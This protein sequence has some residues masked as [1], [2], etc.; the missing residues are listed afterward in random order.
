M[1]VM[2]KRGFLLGEFSLKIIIAVICIVI[3]IFLLVS[4]YSTYSNKQFLEQAKKSIKKI[5]LGL[6]EAEQK[7]ESEVVILYPKS[8]IASPRGAYWWI[9]AWPGETSLP[10]SDAVFLPKRC[11]ENGW[12]NC[13]CICS[14]NTLGN[15]GGAAAECD[16][17]NKGVC[18]ESKHN[19]KFVGQSIWTHSIATFH[20]NPI[21]LKT[22]P[23]TLKIEYKQGE[24]EISLK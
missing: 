4:L 12:K 6:K 21:E 11:K 3:L 18:V 17:I 24:Y 20:P 8:N 2:R 10:F 7:G 9:V 23:F 5:E 22:T 1:R 15:G 19:I 13:I 14:S 16:N